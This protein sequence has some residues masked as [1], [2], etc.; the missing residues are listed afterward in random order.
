M[1]VAGESVE[2]VSWLWKVSVD[3]NETVRYK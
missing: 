3:F 1:A 2:E